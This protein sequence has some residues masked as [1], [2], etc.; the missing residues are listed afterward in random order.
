MIILYKI[1]LIFN[2]LSKPK[3][4]IFYSSEN[5]SSNNSNNFSD[6]F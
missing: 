5:C 4:L 2:N 6:M 3:Y 1:V